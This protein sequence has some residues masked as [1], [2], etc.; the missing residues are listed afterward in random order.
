MDQ[1]ETRTLGGIRANEGVDAGLVPRR[2]SPL[3]PQIHMR[4]GSD[5]RVDVLGPAAL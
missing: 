4:V 5:R 1:F 2:N 3:K